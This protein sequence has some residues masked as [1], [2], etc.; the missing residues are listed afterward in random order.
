MSAAATT[1]SQLG[2]SGTR[3]GP[4]R[5]ASGAVEGSRTSRAWSSVDLPAKRPLVYEGATRGGAL[6]PS[7]GM[8][9]V[10]YWGMGQRPLGPDGPWLRFRWN[11]CL[12][13]GRFSDELSTKDG[14]LSNGITDV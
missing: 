9:W 4:S 7:L 1:I 14:D 5:L 11:W 3:P 6:A 12:F 8:S 2:T 10:S 13:L